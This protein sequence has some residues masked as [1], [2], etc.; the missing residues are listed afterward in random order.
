MECRRRR[1][2]P[3]ADNSTVVPIVF[4]DQADAMLP[5]GDR[6]GAARMVEVL[7]DN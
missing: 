4:D 7:Y 1:G 6:E 3:R 5:T 2:F